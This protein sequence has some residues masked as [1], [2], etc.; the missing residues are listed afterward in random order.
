VSVPQRERGPGLLFLLVAIAGA[1]RLL[2]LFWLHPLNWDEIEYFRA[3]D[4][5]RQG[6]VPYRDFWEHH[7]PLQWFVFA[8]F[9]ALTGSGGADAVVLMRL[10]QAPLWVLTFVMI[11]WWMRDAGIGAFARWAAITVAVCSSMLMIPA[12]EYRV[13]G[14]ACA[15]YAIALV[16]IQR[17]Q[18]FAAGVALCLCGLANLRMGPLLALTAFLFLVIDTKERRWRIRPR[19]LVLAAGVAAAGAVAVAYLVATDSLAALY[20]HVWVENYL[21][22]RYAQ[23]VPLSFAHRM[24]VP[25]GIRIY[26]GGETFDPAGIDL[27]GSALLVAGVIGI[28]YALRAW[29]NPDDAFLL[30]CLQIG[31]IFFIAVMKFVYHY[32]LEIVAVM[33]V[34]FVALVVPRLKHVTPVLILMTLAAVFV[35]VFRGKER[36]FAYQDLIM[37]EV[38]AHTETGAKVFDGVGWALR[39]E[40][41]YRFWFLPELARQLV[42][43]GHAA[44]YGLREWLADP[45][46]AVITDRNAVIWL[47]QNPP[48]ASYVTRHYVPLWRNLWLPG[49]SARLS[50]SQSIEWI[51]PAEGRYRVLA[52]RGMAD[53]PWFNRPFGYS[54]SGVGPLRAIPRNDANI[55]FTLNGNPIDVTAGMIKL[56]KRDRLRATSG[57]LQPVGI[58]ITGGHERTWFR[59]PPPDV[60]LDAEAAR[61]TH[62]P[63]FR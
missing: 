31:S 39:R 13:D 10:F 53:H 33:M 18:A 27:A 6:L 40:P 51:A 20:Q 61:V 4:W 37:R 43:R 60:T 11:N 62:V 58:F 55:S 23:R 15:L 28:V 22:D 38:H 63:S 30:A 3:T 49:L 12:V 52:S 46:A 54:R 36:D 50:P 29:R 1:I 14:L 16:L 2:P 19:A 45:P 9:T 34:P 57:D 35:V 42:G 56:R 44:P 21:G 32:H 48:L 5:V 47:L 24:L 41:A 26:G 8:P 17:R 25:F 59:E 7:T